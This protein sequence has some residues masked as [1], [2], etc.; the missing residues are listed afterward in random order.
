[1]KKLLIVILLT[2]TLMSCTTTNPETLLDNRAYWVQYDG[3][4]I[5]WFDTEFHDYKYDGDEFCYQY[6]TRYPDR[7]H[8][9]S[10]DKLNLVL[11]EEGQEPY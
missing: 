1:M 6:D 3:E 9:Y 8:C 4:S 2:L 5:G 10:L 11:I 7:Y